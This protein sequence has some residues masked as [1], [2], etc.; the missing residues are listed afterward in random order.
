M[1]QQTLNLL[2]FSGFLIFLINLVVFSYFF[3]KPLSRFNLVKH[4]VVGVLGLTAMTIASVVTPLRNPILLT[5]SVRSVLNRDHLITL[6][7]ESQSKH[8]FF[9][10]PEAVANDATA[11][12]GAS[13]ETRDND[14][15]D[16]NVQ[17]QGVQE[18]DV[19]KTDGDFIFYAPRW[20]NVIR[21]MSVLE[22]DT[23]DLVTTIHLTANDQVVYTDSI[24]LT[25]D[26]LIVIGYRYDIYQMGGC[27]ETDENGDTVFCLGFAWWQPTG[28]VIIIDRTTYSIHYTLETNSAFLDHRVVPSFNNQDEK[29]GETL[30]LVGHHYLPYQSDDDIRP[31][32]VENKN[33][34]IYLPYTQ[35]YYFEDSFHD[36]MTTFVGIP[37]M[38]GLPDLSYQ[39]S[40]YLGAIPDYK[41]IYVTPEHLYLGQSNYYWSNTESYQTTTIAKFSFNRLTGAVI[42]QAVGQVYGIAVNQFAMDEYQGYFRIATTENRWRQDNNDFVSTVTNRLY[43]LEDNQDGGF[44]IIGFI[45]EGIGKPGESIV[46]AR[47]AGPLA[48]IVTFLRTDPLYIID[49]SI[50]SSPTIRAEIILPGFDTYQHPWGDDHL[51]GLG[52]QA[53]DQGQI[54]GIKLTA[55]D[56]DTTDAREIQTLEINQLIQALVPTPGEQVWQYAYAEA[57]FDH[58]AILV[59]PE[60]GIFAFAVNV[61]SWGYLNASTTTPDEGDTTSDPDQGEIDYYATFHSFYFIFMINFTETNPIM[62]PTIIEHP[63]SVYD[64]V[65]VDRG[66]MINNIVHTFSSRQIISYDVVNATIIQ[67]FV[68]PKDRD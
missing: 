55:Y 4:I 57:L 51:I 17:V 10:F 53:D 16:T 15:V 35:M 18:G 21:V 64:Y 29:I 34:K 54:S 22:D 65:Q 58:K 32:F 59:S 48:Y 20:Q 66:V 24:Y 9:G 14:F 11:V 47:F 19:I 13:S 26:Y 43:V 33:D 23:L 46:S 67:T 38:D 52:Y 36:A 61:A 2:L 42:F 30:F 6:L 1:S 60:R 56:V 28:S 44:D 50:P 62:L 25:K 8:Q 63:T 7:S 31:Y 49:L 12:P 3:L 27:A 41:K 37:L 39:A 68:F 45:D 5:S 40:A